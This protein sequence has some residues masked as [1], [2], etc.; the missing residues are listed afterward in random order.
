MTGPATGF[1]ARVPLFADLSKKQ[2]DELARSMTERR[3]RAGETLFS[4][5]DPGVAFFVIESGAIDVTIGDRKVATLGEGDH[6]GE[7]ALIE[8]VDRTATLTAATDVRT[9]GIPSWVFRPLVQGNPS[10]AFRL[11]EAMA[12]RAAGKPVTPA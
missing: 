4:E 12:R 1:L 6:F 5:G 3:W 7:V 10:V 2:L 11:L 9:Y 8:E